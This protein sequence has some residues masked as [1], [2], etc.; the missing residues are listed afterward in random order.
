M[1]ARAIQLIFW[2]KEV[3]RSNPDTLLTTVM[4][5]LRVSKENQAKVLDI[6]DELSVLQ[7][8]MTL[9]GAVDTWLALAEDDETIV[10]FTRWNSAEAYAGWTHHPH[11]AEIIFRLQ[12]HLLSA[13]IATFFVP[14]DNKRAYLCVAD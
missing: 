2:G 10:V 1:Q 3:M 4:L 8:S 12:P 11:R 13:P 6:Y 14:P 9:Q 5:T 7:T